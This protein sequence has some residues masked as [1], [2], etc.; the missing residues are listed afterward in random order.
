MARIDPEQEGRRLIEFYAGQMDGELEKVAG[1][2]YELT[3]LAREALRTELLRRGLTAELVETAPV[4]ADKEL[5]AMPGDPPPPEPPPPEPAAA[6]GELE[7]RE[8]GDDP[9]VPRSARGS[10]S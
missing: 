3:D 9:Q 4:V 2:A 1:Q 7:L 8:T 10:A 6:D 5:P